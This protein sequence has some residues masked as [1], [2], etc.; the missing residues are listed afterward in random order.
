M[1]RTAASSQCDRARL[2][3]S[4]TKVKRGL[5]ALDKRWMRYMR[6]GAR[7]LV[8]LLGE[9]AAGG[10]T[11]LGMALG[12]DTALTWQQYARKCDTARRADDWFFY[13]HSHDRSVHGEHGHFHVFRRLPGQSATDGKEGYAHL[14]G[15]GVD[16]RGLPRR[17]FT[18]N[19]WVTNESWRDAR[20]EIN[21]LERIVAARSPAASPL[22]GWLR[23]LLAAFTPQIALL[24]AHRDRR[25][26]THGGARVFEDRRMHV[27]SE[28]AVSLQT[29]MTAIDSVFS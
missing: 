26:I 22:L 12:E 5:R 24:L 19:R 18:T 17:L 6:E 27:L 2:R 3:V 21:A 7:R 4:H 8:D 23:A 9:F 28:C 25:V 10:V 11:P 16:A 14:I 1:I 15:I 29:Q 20:D 13:Y